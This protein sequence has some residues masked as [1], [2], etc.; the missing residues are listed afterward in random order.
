[1]I[2]YIYK[3]ELV[4]ELRCEPAIC[5]AL[6]PVIQPLTY[7]TLPSVWCQDFP[8]TPEEFPVLYFR[9]TAFS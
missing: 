7:Y 5:L 1:M 2:S 3:S 9:M 6:K 8:V 4:E